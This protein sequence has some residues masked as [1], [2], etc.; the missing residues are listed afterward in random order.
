MSNNVLFLIF[1]PKS[2]EK[3][4]I[5]QLVTGLQ[6]KFVGDLNRVSFRDGTG[7]FPHGNTY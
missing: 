7:D 6:G 5:K 4:I 2:K 1:H 3:T